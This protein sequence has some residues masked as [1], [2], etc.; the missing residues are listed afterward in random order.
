M[1]VYFSCSITGGRAEQQIYKQIVD[2]LQTQGWV[3]PTAHLAETGV[4][5]EER[6]IEPRVVY[7]RDVHWVLESD[8]LI[9]EVSTPSHG[10]GYE[11]ALAEINKK[12][13]FCCC[14]QTKKVSKMILG[15]ENPN[16]Q[17]YAYKEIEDLF[18]VMDEFLKKNYTGRKS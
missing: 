18:L 3:V 16:F 6:V 13:I 4:L 2:H 9:A 10:V 7:Q 5:D 1:Q 14:Q 15:N 11:I 8:I 12:P 17:I